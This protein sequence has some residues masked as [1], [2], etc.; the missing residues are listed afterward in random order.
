MQ[1]LEIKT[2]GSTQQKNW[3]RKNLAE[4]LKIHIRDLRPVFLARQV[5]TVLTRSKSV[6]VNLGHLKLIIT[7]H[8]VLISNLKNKWVENIFIPEISTQIKNW[9]SENI[10]F[11]FWVL[12][13]VLAYKI[14]FLRKEY[15]GFEKEGRRLL[16]ILQ[17]S[18]GDQNLEELLS[19]RKKLLKLEINLTENKEAIVEILEDD[20]ALEDLYFSS[21]KKNNFEE[22]ESILEDFLEQTEEMTNH[23]DELQENLNDTQE[24]ISLKM[25]N[26]RNSIIQLVSFATTILTVL[27]VITGVYGMN[28]RNNLEESYSTF[29]LLVGGMWVGALVFFLVG[30]IWLRKRGVL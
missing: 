21:N 17:T 25:S 1:V 4:E 10:R 26:R 16:R 11:E 12:E 2:N 23:I 14:R 30:Y 7:P 15:G 24:I 3:L 27:T 29:L 20:D 8:R 13:F 19:F 18:F 22:M 6:I 5:A 9:D 28:I